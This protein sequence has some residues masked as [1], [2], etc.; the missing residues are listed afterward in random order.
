[1]RASVAECEI[2]TLLLE[3]KNSEE[4]LEQNKIGPKCNSSHPGWKSSAAPA[5]RPR[6]RPLSVS[7][8]TAIPPDAQE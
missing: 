1:M 6:S 2:A 3:N 7:R 8:V 4:M 5:A